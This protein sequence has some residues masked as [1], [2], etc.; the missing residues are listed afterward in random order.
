MSEVT[1]NQAIKYGFAFAQW[2]LPESNITNTIYC[3]ANNIVTI[4]SISEIE[5]HRGFV[6]APFNISEQSPIYII[7][8]NTNIDSNFN[9]KNIQ[10]N[11]CNTNNQFLKNSLIFET[12]YK[13]QVNNVKNKFKNNGLKK[14]VLSRYKLLDKHSVNTI[15]NLFDKLKSNYSSAFVYQLYIPGAGYWAGA[16]PELLFKQD[17]SQITTVSLA[18]TKPNSGDITKWTNKELI[19]Q[20]LV[21]EHVKNV[22]KK[23]D[24]NDYTQTGPVTQSAGKISHLKTTFTFNSKLIKNKTGEFLNSLHPTPAICGLPVNSSKAIILKTEKYDRKY[25]TGFLGPFNLIDKTNLFVNLRCLQAFNNGVVLFAGCG[26][27][28]GSEAENE[29]VETQL[30]IETLEQIIEQL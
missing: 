17:A 4:F 10:Y 9:D 7:P 2:Q 6:F 29:W 21:T 30:K 27:T 1:I 23:F 22:I 25:Y 15:S 8:Y 14:I 11:Y 3:N 28:P 19:E 26:I 20:E 5:N 13:A 24:I 18:G 12:E 16:T